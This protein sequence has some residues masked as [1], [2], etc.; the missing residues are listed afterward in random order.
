MAN[1]IC[2]PIPKMRDEIQAAAPGNARNKYTQIIRDTEADLM[3]S[4]RH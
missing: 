2:E 3:W 1:A 4:A